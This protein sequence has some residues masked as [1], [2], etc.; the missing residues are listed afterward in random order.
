M[1]T[2]RT[3][4]S[5]SEENQITDVTR[6]NIV[7]AISIGQCSWS[8]RLGEAE[9]LSRLFDINKLPS[10]DYRYSTA[11]E[12]IWQH[13]IN[14]SDWPDDW[15]FY[16]DRFDIFRGPDERFL[17]FLCEMVHPVVRPDANDALRLVKLFN[18]HLE[19]DGWEIAETTQISGK[20]VYAA[21]PLIAGAGAPVKAA[22]EMA[23]ILDA[24]YVSQQI[25]RMELAVNS[26]PELAIGTA[27]EFLETICKTILA[28]LG[29]PYDK[30]EKLPKLVK[31]T[32]NEI[33]L[34]P[35]ALANAPQAA[36]DV[37]VLLK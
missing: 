30:D 29:I 10:N 27:K 37:R 8:G 13:R 6:R 33:R 14:N 5:S 25:T 22:K 11:A 36:E 17:R 28:E 21:R 31:M 1:P 34:V 32:V 20:A 19:S 24:A 3:S 15:V 4:S 7:D 16:D 23:F 9:F 12:D 2:R 26:D 35:D 18:G